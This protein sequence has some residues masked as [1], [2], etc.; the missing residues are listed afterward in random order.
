[1]A[2]EGD[3]RNAKQRDEE[4]GDRFRNTHGVPSP[5]PAS[6]AMRGSTLTDPGRLVDR[7]LI[8]DIADRI[9]GRREEWGT[10]GPGER[11]VGAIKCD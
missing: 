3:R 5:P 2:G 4:R 8:D 6:I 7:S 1:L 10:S 11:T 9:P